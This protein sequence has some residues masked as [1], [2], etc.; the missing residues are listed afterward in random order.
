MV[1]QTPLVNDPTPSS[2]MHVCAKKPPEQNAQQIACLHEMAKSLEG[3][4]ADFETV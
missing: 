3:E 1:Y 4:D 2:Q